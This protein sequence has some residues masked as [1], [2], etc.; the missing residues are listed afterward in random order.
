MQN[1]RAIESERR[2]PLVEAQNGFLFRFDKASSDKSKWYWRCNFKGCK[3]RAVSDV[4]SV[5]LFV[6][7]PKHI[8][9]ASPNNLNRRERVIAAKDIAF[10]MPLA[11]ASQVLSAVKMQMT[12]EQLRSFPS[13][14]AMRK[15]VSRVRMPLAAGILDCPLSAVN[16]A[17]A[18]RYTKN[19]ADEQFLIYDSRTQYPNEKIVFGFASKRTL[20][21]LNKSDRIGMD[22]TFYCRPEGF[23]Q[24]YS[25]HAFLNEHC[26]PVAYFLMQDQLTESYLHAFQQLFSLNP[27]YRPASI[28][29][30]MELA[31]I[32]A[33]KTVFPDVR[34][35][36]CL[37]HVSQAMFAK[38]KA[39]GLLPLYDNADVR[40]FLRCFPAMALSPPE[41]VENHYTLLE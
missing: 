26:I 10:R 25:V 31:P 14:E 6:T 27:N 38:I 23:A 19:R 4:N 15:A 20:A 33:I 29:A 1:Q 3:A 9:F 18:E 41:E 11:P 8:D 28:M 36:Y 13:N 17:L 35:N 30:D 2:K 7:Q 24:L 21:F 40:T 12:D 5:N 39:Y 34:V 32:N 22:G 37:F 16:W